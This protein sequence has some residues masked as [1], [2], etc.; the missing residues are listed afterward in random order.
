M[1]AFKIIWKGAVDFYDEMFHF[2]LMGTVTL[3]GCILI[4]PGPFV[5][6]GLYAAAQKAVRGEG[7]KWATY[8]QGI[9]EFGLRT[10]GLVLLEALI[11]LIIYVNFWFYNSEV[12]PFSPQLGLWLTPLWIVLAL[13]WTGISYYAQAFLMELKEPKFFTIFRSSL[14]LAILHPVVTL[15]LLIV[16]LI[17]LALSVV[18]PV[19]LILSPS[20]LLVIA[21]KAVRMQVTELTEKVAELE[22]KEAEEAAAQSEEQTENE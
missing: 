6:A 8:W 13:V 10:W 7:I 19:L 14:F 17:V 3:I 2:L 5:I 4:L 11:Y 16:T 12:S 20:L 15:I 9:K 22:Q 1:I 18:F 21:L